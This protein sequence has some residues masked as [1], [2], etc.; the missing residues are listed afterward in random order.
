MDFTFM[1][2]VA[3]A[4]FMFHEFEEIIFIKP[5]LK[6]KETDNHLKNHYFVSYKNTNSSTIAA[7]IAEE[8]IMVSVFSIAAILWKGYSFIWVFYCIYSFHLL[9]HILELFIYRRYC[10]S[11]ITSILTLPIYT[12]V[13][14]SF[15]R[16]ELLQWNIVLLCSPILLIIIGSNFKFIN[17]LTPRIDQWITCYAKGE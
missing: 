5:W 14:Y 10:P 2:M 6:R 9:G 11:L 17:W 7:L 3:L 16:L 15:I 13:I 8:F 12:W 4:A 1:I